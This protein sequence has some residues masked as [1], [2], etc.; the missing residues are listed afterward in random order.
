LI[1]DGAN[2]SLRAQLNA[3]QYE[4]DSI[5]QEKELI[6]LQHQSELRDLENRAEGDYKR[7]LVSLSFSTISRSV[8]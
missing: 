7:A 1:P 3:L 8:D 4:L 5:K 6:A 2:E